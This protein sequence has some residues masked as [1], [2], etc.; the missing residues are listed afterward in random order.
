M[1]SHVLKT[2]PGAFQA[3]L[4]GFKKV[5]LRYDDRR[6][7]VGDVLVLMETKYSGNEMRDTGVPL[8]Y[9]GRA[10][11]YLVTHLQRGYGLE[12]GWVA[13]SL[14]PNAPPTERIEQ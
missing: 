8:Q 10:A 5:E 6:Y 11:E 4:S 9:T 1:A 3:T 13:L 12:D 2:D 14:A 7:A